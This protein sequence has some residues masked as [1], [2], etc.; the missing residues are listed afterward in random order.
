MSISVTTDQGQFN[1]PGAYADFGTEETNSGLATT[2]VVLLV[3]EADA[4]P[5][6]T[7]ESDL[8]AN[9]FGPDEESAVIAKYGSGWI[10]DAFKAACSPSKD[11]DITGAPA[12]I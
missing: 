4:G 11:P 3:G 7:L 5:D 2:G 12:L 8:D 6:Y 9:S 10:V 1:I